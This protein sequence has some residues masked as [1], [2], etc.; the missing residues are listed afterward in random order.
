MNKQDFHIKKID[1]DD[2]IEIVLEYFLEHEFY[3]CDRSKG[4][5]L[6]KPGKDLRFIGIYGNNDNSGFSE[7]DFE[8]L[9]KCVAFNGDHSFLKANPKFNLN[10]N[11][12]E[13]S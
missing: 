2:I 5:L 1:E 3:S 10:L 7:Y 9:D 8:E 11:N 12:H 4:I 6:G 13:P